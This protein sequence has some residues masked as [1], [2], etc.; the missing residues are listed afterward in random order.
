MRHYL[1]NNKF[2]VSRLCLPFLKAGV[3][4]NKIEAFREL[5]EENALRLTDRRNM[6]DYIPFIHQEEES[7]VH[8]E[9]KAQNVFDNTSRLGEALAI[10]I[11][12]VSPD[13][14]IE[15]RLVRVQML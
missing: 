2:I 12:F 11:R 4:L 1:N 8:S 5:L 14:R 9:I 6:H 7:R 10:I 15:Q 3:P 13:W